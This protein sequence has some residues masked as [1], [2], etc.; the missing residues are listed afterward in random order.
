[1]DYSYVSDHAGKISC[2]TSSL[3]SLQ[4]F[5]SNH[6]MGQVDVI[7]THHMQGENMKGIAS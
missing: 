1:M 7:W 4:A 3:V 5:E 2:S 6:E